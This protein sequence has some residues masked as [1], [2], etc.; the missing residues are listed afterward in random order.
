MKRAIYVNV[1]GQRRDMIKPET[2]PNLF[3][4]GQSSTR[5][6]KHR[7]VFP[8]CTRVVSASVATGCHP[9]T[10]GLQGNSFALLEDD[11]IVVH[12]AGRPDFLEH[13]R[14]VTGTA[15]ARPTMA[16]FLK[17][18]GGSLILSN[19]SPGAATAHDPDG[20]GFLHHRAGSYGPGPTALTGSD[21]LHIEQGIEGDRAMTDFLID[22][23]DRGIAPAFCVLWYGQPD[24][25]Q[26]FHPLGSPDHRAM[27]RQ[28]DNLV[29]TVI[30]AVDARRRAGDDILLMI[31]SDHGHQTVRA[32]IDIDAELIEAGLKS[33]PGSDDVVSVSNGTSAFVY[34]H[35][36]A[37]V[38]ASS[39]GAFLK[40]QPWVGALFGPDEMHE[41]GQ[42]PVHGLC[43]VLS[44]AEVADKNDYGIAYSSFAAKPAAGKPDIVGA[45]QHG[46]LGQGEQAPF[47]FV[48][49]AGF[50]SDNY[51]LAPTSVLDI[52]PTVLAHFELTGLPD[53]PFDGNHLPLG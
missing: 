13:K 7:S 32:I 25:V 41:V 33:G 42:I 19:V 9:G 47:L 24:Y 23:L 29:G 18:R 52:V 4:F 26:H 35:P 17:A 12:D 2:M 31:G 44:M 30:D 11:V 45:G 6:Q 21:A 37:A 53:L 50:Q 5:C 49:G 20:H 16:Q 46:G 3:R 34:R 28:T 14:R 1:D 51:V 43:F 39:L 36:D 10:H 8:S 15:L 22:Q 48:Q 38:E 27:M 40:T